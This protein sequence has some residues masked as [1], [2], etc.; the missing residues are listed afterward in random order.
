MDQDANI[1]RVAALGIASD[2]G[3]L[4]SMSYLVR[5]CHFWI[6]RAVNRSAR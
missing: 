5:T 2:A 4:T 3:M 1:G 6:D